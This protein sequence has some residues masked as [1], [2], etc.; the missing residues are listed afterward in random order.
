MI[1]KSLTYVALIVNDVEA[2]AAG[3]Q[4]DFDLTRVDC[5]VGRGER[6]APVLPIGA[7]ALALFA[8]GDPFVGGATA[9]GVHHVALGVEDLRAAAGAA[10]V[11]GIALGEATASD[12]LGGGRRL[13]LAPEATAGVRTYLSEPLALDRGGGG[14]VERIDHLGVASADN[15]AAL[16]V[17]T[18]RLGCALESTQTDLEVHVA[19]ESFTSDKYGVVYHTRPPAPAGGLRVAFVTVGDS[20]LEF[21]QEF[22][23]RTGARAARGAPG[24]T[25]QDQGAIGRFIAKRGPGLHH[26][27]LKVTDIDGALEALARA[28][29]A[30]I[31]PVGRPGSRRAL[32]GFIHPESFHG[33][34]VHLV[35]RD[36]GCADYARVAPSGSL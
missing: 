20:E 26:L 4:R 3:L 36:G 31:D 9:T 15:D 17:F 5:R 32:I 12:G 8:P 11:A 23:P 33:V 30:L 34:L 35:Q 22:D 25:R 2:A 18:R 19:I 24:T 10:S 16:E 1:G 6:R 13:L 28:G 29:R 7:S 27:A 14:P 21:L